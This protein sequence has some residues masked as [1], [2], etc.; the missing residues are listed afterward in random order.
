MGLKVPSESHHNIGHGLGCKFKRVNWG[1]HSI[2]SCLR[3]LEALLFS[4]EWVGT[5]RQVIIEW[6]SV[7][8]S[9]VVDFARM[10]NSSVFRDGLEGTFRPVL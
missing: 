4:T 9:E 7:K 6:R 3:I 10:D 8:V 5:C 2:G 1:L